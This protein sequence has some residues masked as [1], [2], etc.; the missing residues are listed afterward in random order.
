MTNRG[1]G[2]SREGG[3]AWGLATAKIHAKIGEQ[4]VQKSKN[5][6][7]RGK[8]RNINR[9]QAGKWVSGRKRYKRG[10]AC[11]AWRPRMQRGVGQ[12]QRRLKSLIIASNAL[13]QR[14][15][16]RATKKTRSEREESPKTKILR[17]K[18]QKCAT[19]RSEI[20]GRGVGGREWQHWW[21]EPSKRG[22]AAA[23]SW[24]SEMQQQQ[25]PRHL[26]ALQ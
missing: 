7:K 24:R 25:Q 8:K 6:T 4:R 11:L 1:G 9:K 13:A 12:V 22:S 26:H 23:Q 19:K 21:V 3:V 17:E 20:R 14:A 2:R 5:E 15:P 10:G 18:M 16:R